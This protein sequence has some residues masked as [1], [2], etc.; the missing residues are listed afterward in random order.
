MQLLIDE[1]SKALSLPPDK[2]VWQVIDDKWVKQDGYNVHDGRGG[3]LEEMPNSDCRDHLLS[4]LFNYYDK[5][6]LVNLYDINYS[7]R[8]RF[9]IVL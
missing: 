6:T 2:L 1:Q 8:L 7:S 4:C 9:S 5:D 3:G